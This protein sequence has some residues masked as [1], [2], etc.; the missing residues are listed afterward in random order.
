MRASFSAMRRSS[1]EASKTPPNLEDFRV[2]FS[3][4][5]L[6][7]VKHDGSPLECMEY[8]SADTPAGQ[9]PGFI[10]SVNLKSSS[11]NRR[12]NKATTH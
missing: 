11:I 6:K 12:V 5:C 2:E 8:L 4:R 1:V 10:R 7:F 3:N 9:R